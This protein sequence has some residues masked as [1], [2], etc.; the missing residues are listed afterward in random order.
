MQDE[1]KRL[2]KAAD[3]L[4]SRIEC[5]CRFFETECMCDACDCGGPHQLSGFDP[6]RPCQEAEAEYVSARAFVKD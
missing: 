2:I 5:G 6:C 4:H 1:I 3:A